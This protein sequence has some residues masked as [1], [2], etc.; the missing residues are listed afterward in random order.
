MKKFNEWNEVKKRIDNKTKISIPKEREV[1]WT[2]IGENVGFEQNGKSKLFTRPVLVLKR[3]NKHIFFGIPL[4]TQIKEGNFFFTF[5][6]NDTLSNALLVQGK[7]FDIKRLEKKI[8]MISKD[9]FIE[10]KT[11]FRE[12]LDV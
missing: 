10:L 12:L 9:E 11:R 5:T 7:L 8:G 3:F 6:L 2:C 4:S 1:Y